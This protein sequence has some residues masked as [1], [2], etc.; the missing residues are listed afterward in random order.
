MVFETLTLSF[1]IG[2]LRGG[3]IRNLEQLYIKAWYLIVISFGIEIMSLLIIRNTK[4]ELAN[5][6]YNNFFKINIIIYIFLILGLFFNIGEKGFLITFIGTLLNFFPLL[7]NN[8]RMPVSLK[9]LE[10]SK[11][12]T[13]LTLLEE[14]KILTHSL[15]DINTKLKLLCDIIPIP[16]PYFMPKIISIGDI[17]IAVGLFIIIQKYMNL[18]LKS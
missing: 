2:K 11:L 10:I 9:G 4:G 12:Y 16:K 17:F 13:Q 8:G 1:L 15:M 18:H 5:L 6:I 14:N 7:F 3:R